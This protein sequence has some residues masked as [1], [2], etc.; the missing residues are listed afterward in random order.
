MACV[1]KLGVNL[2]SVAPVDGGFV[3]TGEQ[4]GLVGGQGDRGDGAHNLGL[5]LDSHAFDVHLGDGAISSSDEEVSVLDKFDAVDTLLEKSL[6]GSNPLEEAS[7]EVN[8]DDITSAGSEVGELV[9][10]GDFDALENS[11]NLTHVDVLV[12]NFL[13][14]EV[15][16]PHSEAVVVD[17]NQLGGG[18][19]EEDNFVG[20][21]VAD[22]VSADRFAGSDLK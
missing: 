17:S 15:A 5:T 18:V 6:V 8:L 21:V 20:D 19:L 16:V 22:G 9:V 2:V 12:T 14:V 1:S 7:F 10:G 11:L 3:G 13:S 4:V